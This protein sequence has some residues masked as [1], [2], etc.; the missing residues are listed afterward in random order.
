MPSEATTS[1]SGFLAELCF[2]LLTENFPF[3]FLNKNWFWLLKTA[4]MSGP[5]K[6]KALFSAS[7]V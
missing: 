3:R 4:P 6:E 7:E 2:R 5:S 1:A